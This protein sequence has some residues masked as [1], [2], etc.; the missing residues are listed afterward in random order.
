MKR[1][2]WKIWK[3]FL[4]VSIPINI[5]SWIFFACCLDSKSII[6]AVIC[7]INGL[8]LGLIAWANSESRYKRRRYEDEMSIEESYFEPL[9]RRGA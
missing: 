3:V 2:L 6:P 5:V 8:W 7:V 9:P 1:K 4:K